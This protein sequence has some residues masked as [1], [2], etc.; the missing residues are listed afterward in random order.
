MPS[1]FAREEYQSAI[2]GLGSAKSRLQGLTQPQFSSTPAVSA[3]NKSALVPE[4][5]YLADDWLEDDSEEFQPK[6]K[7]R[8]REEQTG[9]RGEGTASSSS[10]RGQHMQLTSETTSRGNDFTLLICF[11]P[12]FFA[13]F[14]YI[15]LFFYFRL[16]SSI[17]F[18]QG[19]LSEKEQL[20]EAS[21]G[22]N[23][24]NAGDG[25][26]R[27]TRGQQVSQSHSYR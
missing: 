26:V 6:K 11:T 2:R 21:P 7:R 27:P 9:F 13:C 5:E 15:L 14:N 1:V 16:C 23:D 20:A 19:S 24:S 17:L 4:E 12:H 8:L 22:Q 25:Q 3:S 18:Q 10:A